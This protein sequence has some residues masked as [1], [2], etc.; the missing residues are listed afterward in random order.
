MTGFA[1][2]APRS[3]QSGNSSSRARG[4]EHRPREDVRANLRALFH[5]ADGDLASRRLAEL[6]QPDGRGEAGRAA[7]HDHGVEIHGLTLYFGHGGRLPES[8]GAAV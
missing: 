4:L 3:L 6:R 1:N 8:G 2:G 7:A 5:E